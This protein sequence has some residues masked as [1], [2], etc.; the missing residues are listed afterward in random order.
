MQKLLAD[1]SLFMVDVTTS[2]IK[3]IILSTPFFWI[4]YLLQ[5]R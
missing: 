3:N 1:Y 5:N 4:N 2:L